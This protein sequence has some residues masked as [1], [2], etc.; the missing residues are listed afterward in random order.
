MP[1]RFHFIFSSD[2]IYEFII[3]PDMMLSDP[4]YWNII[5]FKPDLRMVFCFINVLMSIS[6]AQL[7]LV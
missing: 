2:L 7:L 6:F 4:I 3:S 1:Y 5:T